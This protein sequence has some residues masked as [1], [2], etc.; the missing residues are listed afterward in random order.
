MSPTRILGLAIAAALASSVS[1][2]ATGTPEPVLGTARSSTVDAA[3]AYTY[4]S[5]SGTVAVTR[6]NRYLNSETPN[7]S[8]IGNGSIIGT[9]TNDFN[10]TR[11]VRRAPASREAPARI[12]NIW[13]G[14]DHQ[15]TESHVE[16]AE[17]AR[18]VAPSAEQQRRESRILRELNRA[19]LKSAGATAG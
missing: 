19:L 3:T 8:K 5:K 12:A 2:A 9:T 17:R 18:G 7:L 10:D 13:G 14:F 4:G 16:H 15:P 6:N 1:L 11:V